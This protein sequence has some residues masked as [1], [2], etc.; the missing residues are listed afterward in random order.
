MP[1]SLSNVI[2]HLVFSTKDRAPLIDAAIEPRLHAYLATAIRDTKSECYRVGGVLDH[3]H[4]AIRLARTVSQS[5]LVELIKRT[6]SKWIKTH[7]PQYQN[8]HWQKGFGCF[9]ISHSHLDPLIAYVSNQP[10]HHRKLTFQDEF[11]KLCVKNG[12]EIDEK[13]VWE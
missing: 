2:I 1:Q 3:V 5:E 9:S 6:S 13:Y 7:G 4:F 10:A 8:F 12:V 11:R